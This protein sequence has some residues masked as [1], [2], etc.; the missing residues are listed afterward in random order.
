MTTTLVR[1]LE[2]EVMDTAEEAEDYDAMD[3]R[4]V[5]ARFC[6]DVIAEGALEGVVLDVGTGTAL[7]PVELCAREPALRVLGIDLADH[8]LGRGKENVARAGLE[9]RVDLRKVDAKALPFADGAFSAALS[10]SIIHHI[11][12]PRS[13]LA[14]MKRV[15][16][17]GGVVFVRDLARPET[18][19]ELE[20]LV[21]L[22]AGAPPDDP[23]PRARFERQR[24]LLRASLAAS[25]TAAE[26]HRIA[27]G[28]GLA[29]CTVRATSDRHW[30][31][32][33]RK[34]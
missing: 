5:N 33:Y 14:E 12:D 27:T 28:V 16:A 11:P 10:N 3:H 32:S 20:R 21:H 29:S 19:A 4:A 22:H 18:E 34:T 6:E 17:S 7:I 13:V 24:E 26:I 2:P 23:A 15:V 8:M 9:G 30:T 25:F 31:L 1:V